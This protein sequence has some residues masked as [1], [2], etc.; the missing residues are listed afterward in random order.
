MNAAESPNAARL[1]TKFPTSSPALQQKNE[2]R[3]QKGSHID[4]VAPAPAPTSLPAR[5]SA[6]PCV[7]D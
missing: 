7:F 6:T 2:A 4:R 1:R 5:L 3:A